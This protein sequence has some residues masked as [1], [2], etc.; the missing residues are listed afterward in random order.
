LQEANDVSTKRQKFPNREFNGFMNLLF[1]YSLT[2]AR[3]LMCGPN[4][5]IISKWAFIGPY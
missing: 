3:V 5:P 2:Y 1:W 4:S